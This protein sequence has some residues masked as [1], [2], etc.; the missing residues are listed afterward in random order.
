[1]P[2]LLIKRRVQQLSAKDQEQE[3]HP[4]DLP[5]TPLRQPAI[6]PR[7]NHP[8]KQKIESGK[9]SQ[10]ER[11]PP[12]Q[13]RLRA[14]QP[15]PD[16]RQAN[17]A[18]DGR[19]VKEAVDKVLQQ[20]RTKAH[21][22]AQQQAQVHMLLKRCHHHRSELPQKQ[23]RPD[24]EGQKLQIS[25]GRELE[26]PHPEADAHQQ[27][28]KGEKSDPDDACCQLEI[29]AAS[30][31][32]IQQHPPAHFRQRRIL[33]PSRRRYHESPASHNHDSSCAGSPA[34]APMTFRNIS[35]SVSFSPDS[36]SPAPSSLVSTPAR[37]SSS[38]PFATSRPLWMM[39]TWLQSRSTISS[40]CDVRKIVAPR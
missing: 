22:K 25:I 14:Y 17:A 23:H 16:T 37:S 7:K 19:N 1:M 32:R 35:S 3:D 12:D 5:G 9:G 27:P 38:D 26:C 13:M 15:G 36:G 31:Q 29:A 8:C 21:R 39:A 30:P 40:T 20:V 2:R 18:E 33:S 4:Q 34:P 6:Q 10:R 28:Q 24:Q 11:H